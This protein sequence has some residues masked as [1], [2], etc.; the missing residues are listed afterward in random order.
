MAQ[1]ARTSGIAAITSRVRRLSSRIAVI[2]N[3]P[4]GSAAIVP[5]GSAAINTTQNNA[6]PAS[7]PS[8]T[9]SGPM[10]PASAATMP[11]ATTYQQ[12]WRSAGSVNRP[13]ACRSAVSNAL[14]G[15]ST[16]IGASHRSS[17]TASRAGPAPPATSD[18]NP[19]AVTMSNTAMAAPIPVSSVAVRTK[20]A[21]ARESPAV[22]RASMYS[23]WN[24]IGTQVPTSLA[25][26]SAS[27]RA[28]ASASAP[29]PVPKLAATTIS[30]SSAT[31]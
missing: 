29:R 24:R 12:T 3:V 15:P 9:A 28:S 25:I 27:P 31:A 30:Y 10:R 14:R 22:V 18:S 1:D 11:T 23:G 16:T 2:A 21:A 20:N 7:R 4:D 19:G 5:A 13:C 17:G 6:S 8:G 26:T